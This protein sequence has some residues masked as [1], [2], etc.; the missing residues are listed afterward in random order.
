MFSVAVLPEN[1]Q[2]ALVYNMINHGTTVSKIDLKSKVLDKGFSL[3]TSLSML[4]K[5]TEILTITQLQNIDIYKD[6]QSF[7]KIDLTN[8]N[9]LFK[10]DCR[11]MKR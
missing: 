7:G 8:R 9:K 10:S 3:A 5:D 4:V 2:M 6:G 1:R 11:I